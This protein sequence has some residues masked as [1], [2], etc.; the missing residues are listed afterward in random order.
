MERG[1]SG[2]AHYDRLS[3]LDASFLEIEDKNT[4]MHVAAV[5]VFDKGPLATPQGGVDFERLCSTLE[6]G[7]DRLP[8]YRQRLAWVPWENHP[9][10]VDDE[11]FDIHYHLRHTSLPQPGDARQLKRLAGRIMS[12]KLDPGK[13]LWEFWVV[14]GL[15]EDRFA[16][17]TKIHHCMI[18]GISGVDV[19]AT[20]MDT[21][22]DAPPLA[23][24]RWRPR[25]APGRAELVA[26]ELRRYAS[27][28]FALAKRAGEGLAD[29]AAA[30]RKVRETA[31]GLADILG[32]AMRPASATPLNPA[33][34]G[35]HRRFDWLA[36]DL[37]HVKEVKRQLGGT[38]N[39]VVLAVVAGAVRGFLQKRSFPLGGLDFRAMVPVSV[40]ADTERGALGNRVAT[41]LATL[42]VDESSPR[43][44]YE[45]VL[46]TM[47]RLKRSRQV[48]G[49]ELLEE[50]SDWTSTA[51][52]TL[53]VRQAVR[54]RSYNLVVTNVPGPPV[55]V[56]LL[57]APL[58]EFYPMV[59]LYTNQ[60]LGVAL[61]SYAGRLYWGFNSDW[62]SVP[63]LHDFVEVVAGELEVLRKLASEGPAA[64]R[65]RRA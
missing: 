25:P 15:P 54:L 59:P 35:P 29:P 52:L 23:P 16:L 8:R 26:G 20:I 42:P 50:I 38:L 36:V 14:E 3:G 51:L 28:P 21:R 62:D 64:P 58:V 47:G 4:H 43:K 55:P 27:I 9:V 19:L 40:R 48:R 1:T 18:D 49:A 17:V 31:E 34:I 44:R 63:D 22:R 13:P 12:Q 11:S 53:I 24:S 56:Y 61:M 33:T 60:A 39:D 2:P 45:E 30:L 57:G 7:I 32:G 65:R 37:D 5:L 46:S 10:W 6:S 41:L